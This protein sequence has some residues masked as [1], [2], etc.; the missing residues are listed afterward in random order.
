MS[1]RIGDGRRDRCMPRVTVARE[2]ILVRFG[3]EIRAHGASRTRTCGPVE[4]GI[5]FVRQLVTT[6][7]VPALA[8]EHQAKALL[9]PISSRRFD[10]DD[11]HPTGVDRI[12]AC[13]SIAITTPFRGAWLARACWCA[14]MAKHCARCSVPAPG[15]DRRALLSHARSHTP[16]L[17]EEKRPVLLVGLFGAGATAG[18]IDEVPKG[19]RVRRARHALREEAHPAPPTLRLGNPALDDISLPEPHLARY[20]A[21]RR[22]GF[23][24]NRGRR[25]P[26][27]PAAKSTTFTWISR[28]G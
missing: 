27:P 28:F 7:K 20:D 11:L 21:S 23:S 25:N 1:E 16:L 17:F 14:P 9:R 5:G 24:A 19:R 6:G 10:T 3:A 8:F 13:T 2:S 4:R 22:T 12:T 15:P 26:R 18:A